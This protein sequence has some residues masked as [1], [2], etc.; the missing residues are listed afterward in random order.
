VSGRELGTWL[1]GAGLG[2]VLGVAVA[3]SAGEGAV[4]GVAGVETGLLVV[5]YLLDRERRGEGAD[6]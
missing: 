4:Y 2:S 5:G 3:A 6:A 1:Q